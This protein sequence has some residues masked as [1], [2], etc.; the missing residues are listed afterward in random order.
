MSMASRVLIFVIIFRSKF[1]FAIILGQP[2][3]QIQIGQQRLYI[4][5]TIAT[6]T[7]PLLFL[8]IIDLSRGFGTSCIVV[9][10]WYNWLSR[11]QNV[12]F[13]RKKVFLTLILWLAHSFT[14]HCAQDMCGWGAV[15]TWLVLL[16]WKPIM[17]PPFSPYSHPAL[18]T[19]SLSLSLAL[20]CSWLKLKNSNLETV[21]SLFSPRPL[22][23]SLS[24]ALSL[25]QATPCQLCEALHFS[26]LN[27]W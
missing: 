12:F 27:W 17:E 8:A 24:L 15:R 18:L 25:S 4:F 20:I 1:C 22:T 9:F 19:T 26:L 21:L 13:R 16:G 3:C 11:A 2:V 6:F 5:C 14:V 23:N 7:Y 10:S